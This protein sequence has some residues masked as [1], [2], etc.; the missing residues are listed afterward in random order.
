MFVPARRHIQL[1]LREVASEPETVQA[2]ETPAPWYYDPEQKCLSFTLDETASS[3]VIEFSIR[4][5]E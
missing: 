5:G 3:Q 1:E 4:A 2:G